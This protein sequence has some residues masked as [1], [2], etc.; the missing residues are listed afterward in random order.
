[1][2]N[3]SSSEE[4]VE[5][6]R[7]MKPL[8]SRERNSANRHS[9]Q[10]VT[11]C[12][13]FQRMLRNSI[14]K[15]SKSPSRIKNDVDENNIQEQVLS[16]FDRLEDEFEEIAYDELVPLNLRIKLENEVFGWTNLFSEFFGYVFFTLSAYLVAFWFVSYFG[17][18]YVNPIDNKQQDLPHKRCD[19]DCF[20][21]KNSYYGRPDSEYTPIFG[22]PPSLYI[23]LRFSFSLCS[24]LNAFRIARRRRMVWL[25]STT[26]KTRVEETDRTTLLGRIRGGVVRRKNVWLSRRTERKLKKATRRFQKRHQSRRKLNFIEQSEKYEGQ[27]HERVSQLG[28]KLKPRKRVT[29]RRRVT[30]SQSFKPLKSMNDL[31]PD[32]F[33]NTF[34]KYEQRNKHDNGDSFQFSGHTMPNSIMQSIAQDQ[35]RFKNGLIQTVP[36]AHGGYFGTAPFMLANPFWINILRHLMPDVYVELSQ[37]VEYTPIP[38]LIVWAENNPVVAA[39]GTAHELEFCGKMPT[40][41]WDVFLDPHLEQRIQIVLDAREE[42]VNNKY[43]SSVSSKIGSTKINSFESFN[44]KMKA[45]ERYLE[46]SERTLLVFYG[47]EIKK[48]VNTLLEGMLIAHGNLFQLALEQTGFLKQY[49]FSRTKHLRRTLGGG[50]FCKNWLTIYAEALRISSGLDRSRSSSSDEERSSSDSSTSLQSSSSESRRKLCNTSE[51]SP[52]LSNIENLDM[53]DFKTKGRRQKRR[54]LETKNSGEDNILGYERQT[55]IFALND[56]INKGIRR[57]TSLNDLTLSG[58]SSTSISEA[59][60]LLKK[61]TNSDAPLGLVLDIKSRHV[62]KKIWALV[63]D[64]LREAGA[65]VEGIASFCIQEIRDISQYCAVPVNDMIFF[66][67]AGDLQV[68]CHDGLIKNGDNVF[69]NAGS[70]FWNYPDTSDKTYFITMF[71]TM[72]TTMF[73]KPFDEEKTKEYKFQ[74]YAR[75]AG[76]PASDS[77]LIGIP[78]PYSNATKVSNSDED[79]PPVRRRTKRSSLNFLGGHGS[80]IQQYKDHFELSIGMYVQEFAI[81]EKSID[82][83]VK[84]INLNSHVFNLGLSWGGINGV[85]VKGIHPDR[86]TNT[87]GFWNQ[88]YTGERW[89]TDKFPSDA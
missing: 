18:K 5:M 34:Q 83:I 63:V 55:D 72:L 65:R 26:L 9:P 15:K 30:R 36:Y 86:F 53:D 40:L 58:C 78:E 38:K 59:I 51:N 45:I 81:D 41:E 62:S 14:S 33:L 66:H 2:D 79:D 8:F 89:D 37:R 50:I 1:M 28:S 80:T 43:L 27:H 20:F 71:I 75:V 35:I 70:L 44:N 74:S 6:E 17:L 67:S 61:I 47:V 22:V 31:D 84:Y 87:D 12:N 85:T 10:Q 56:S 39:Y 60:G 3:F 4:E 25:H 82:L 54:I 52:L 88:R 23:F 21:H 49:N 77:K 76:T 46:P 32:D 16:T 42:F 48:R 73:C 64:G 24:A 13:S 29:N 57:T 11:S 68:A 19:W 7:L 69:F